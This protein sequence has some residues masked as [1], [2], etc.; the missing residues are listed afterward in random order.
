MFLRN[1][2]Q[3]W[4]GGPIDT[5]AVGREGADACAAPPSLVT[6][7][8]V[9]AEDFADLARVLHCDL[10]A[11]VRAIATAQP[12]TVTALV[13]AL[14]AERAL[15]PKD[16]TPSQAP[17]P[18]AASWGSGGAVG[19]GRWTRARGGARVHRGAPATTNRPALVAP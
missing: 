12:P 6:E 11:V 19:W 4:R 2:L 9:D 16:P 10:P 18:I 13:T 17:T 1:V 5:A 3:R 7:L 15:E 14:D 8:L